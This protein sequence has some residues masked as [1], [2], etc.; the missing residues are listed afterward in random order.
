[1][2]KI[3]Y[4]FNGTELKDGMKAKLSISASYGDIEQIY[5]IQIKNNKLY[6]IINEKDT[7]E[8]DDCFVKIMHIVS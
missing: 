2:F 7:R 1:M 3:K 4:Y 5:P 8:I 6:Y